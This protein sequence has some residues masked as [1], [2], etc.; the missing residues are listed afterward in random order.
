MNSAPGEINRIIQSL[1]RFNEQQS[2]EIRKLKE[3]VADYRDKETR[4]KLGFPPRKL[5][6][7]YARSPYAKL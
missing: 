2:L 6:S 3:L 1:V 4:R 5:T 7:D